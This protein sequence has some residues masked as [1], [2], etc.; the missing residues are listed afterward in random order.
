M[1]LHVI[2]SSRQV[3]PLILGKYNGFK[4]SR[5][6]PS[7]CLH[8]KCQKQSLLVLS[9]LSTILTKVHQ[10]RMLRKRPMKL[11]SQNLTTKDNSS[12][13]NISQQLRRHL[14]TKGLC[15][16]MVFVTLHHQM[17]RVVPLF[18]KCLQMVATSHSQKTIP[19]RMADLIS[20]KA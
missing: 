14:P 15:L 8:K 20:Q 3:S 11:G 17:Q 5:F 10:K 7:W 16:D 2:L 19:Q 13:G 6:I 18:Q 1:A 9:R 4:L 12:S